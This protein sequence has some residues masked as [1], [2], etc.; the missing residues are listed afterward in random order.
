[1]KKRL[2]AII[3]AAIMVL[4]LAA[5]A[6]KPAQEAPKAEEPKAEETKV[7]ETK[8]PETTE[9]PEA[10]VEE[11]PAEPEYEET[12]ITFSFFG[13]ETTPSGMGIEK[14]KELIEEKTAGKVTVDTYYNGTLYN[15]D[16]DSEALMKGSV[17]MIVG[18]VDSLYDYIPELKSTFGPYLWKSMEH[19]NAFWETETGAALMQRCADELGIHF[20]AFNC[21]GWRHIN[22]NE[23]RKISSR[24]DLASTKLRSATSEAMLTMT[25]SL[26]ANPIPIPFSDTYLSIQTNVVSGNEGDVNG[27]VSNGLGEVLKSITLTKH[28]I[29]TN[30]IWCSQKSW[31]KWSP[32]VQ[33]IVK[34]CAVESCL[35]VNG[36]VDDLEKESVATLEAQGIV[37]Y[38]LTDEEREAYR[39]EVLEYFM[40]TDFAADYDKAVYDAVI[41]CGNNF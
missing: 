37:F 41:E 34:E 19:Y 12:K 16:S 13:A 1:M 36:L 18:S 4:G 40:S 6:A 14:F 26:G 2:I 23:D 32:A 9:E 39:Q 8:E 11:T 22:L 10:V 20:L 28:C 27:T 15:Q 3:L 25:E 5:C 21:S 24:G 30:A 29:S 33:E 17:D 38:E 35:Y 31:E 7:E